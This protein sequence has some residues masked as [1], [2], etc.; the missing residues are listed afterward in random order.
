MS[1]TEHSES[2]TSNFKVILTSAY[3]TVE[4]YC[5]SVA[6]PGIGISATPTKIGHNTIKNPGDKIDFDDLRFEILLDRDIASYLEIL[7]LFVQEVDPEE[8][9]L[10]PTKVIFDTKII[11]YDNSRH[12]IY[13]FKYI[14]SF[15]TKLDPIVLDH[16]KTEFISFG[17]EMCYENIKIT[18]LVRT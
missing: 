13:E 17:V 8:G 18:N 3:G 15:I 6:L 14:N 5:Q 7:N 4:R 16:R 2:N 11:I 12:P 9:I 10:Q 1:A